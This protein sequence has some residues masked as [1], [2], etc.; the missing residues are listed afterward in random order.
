[1]MCVVCLEAALSASRPPEY[2]RRPCVHFQQQ[3]R[4]TNWSCSICIGGLCLFQV[5]WGGPMAASPDTDTTTAEG[6][7]GGG[8]AAAGESDATAVLGIKRVEIL[9]DIILPVCSNYF[10]LHCALCVSWVSCLTTGHD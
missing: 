8:G 3:S 2:A 6:V 7:A 1:M 9:Q 4:P 5:L 10:L